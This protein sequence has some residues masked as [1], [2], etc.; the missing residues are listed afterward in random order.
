MPIETDP[1]A[2]ED[3]T[4]S[5]PQLEEETA[6][7]TE[8]SEESSE[9]SEDQGKPEESEEV[10]VVVEGD[11]PAKAEEPPKDAKAWSKARQVERE[12]RERVSQLER[13]AQARSQPAAEDPGEKPTKESCEWDEDRHERELLAW[14]KKNDARE[15]KKVKAAEVAEET[16]RSWAQTVAV[17]DQS[18]AELIKRMPV[19]LERESIAITALR[20]AG[21]DFDPIAAIVETLEDKKKYPLVIAALGRDPAR[22]KD[23]V[24]TRSAARFV[25]KVSKLEDR[26]EMKEKPKGATPPPPESKPKGTG[27]TAG[28]VD[29]QRERLLDEASK[30][31]NIDKLRAYDKS[32]RA[33]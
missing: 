12:L 33:K 24:E 11:T 28:A 5:S 26:V 22:L 21:L 3:T 1:A 32:K 15:A 7:S 2:P 31:G 25:A 9:T 14:H 19:Y 20:S 17:A 10:D 4:T 8:K 13:E 16:K 18:R 30:S 6:E 23:L 29:H 27:A